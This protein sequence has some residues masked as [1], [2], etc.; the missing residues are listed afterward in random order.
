MPKIKLTKTNVE[1]IPFTEK[2]QKIYF[3][4][5]LKG[6]GLLV[7][8]TVKSY[9]A[10]KDVRRRTCR[11]N[12]GRHPAWSVEEARKKARYYTNLMDNGQDPRELEAQE[13]AKNITFKQAWD[14]HRELLVRKEGS[15]RT[16]EIY[17]YNINKHL[18]DW[19]KRP[20]NSIKRSEVRE[21]HTILGSDHGIYEANRT[22]RNFRAVYNTALKEYEHLPPNPVIA[23]QWFKERRRQEPIADNKLAAWYKKVMAMRSPVRKDLQLFLIFT[24]LRRTDACTIR[25]EDINLEKA[26][27]H[28]PNPK[29]GKD[30]AFTVP[31]P[32]IC[33]EILE[34]RK[35][36]NKILY[37]NKCEWVFPTYNAHNELIGVREPKERRRDLPSPHRLRDTYTTAANSAGLSPYDIDVL[38][39]HRPPNGSV[40]AGYIR[41][42][43]EYLRA[44]QQKIAD[45]LKEKM[46][47]IENK[48]LQFK[49][50]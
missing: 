50:V 4:T 17:D 3:D 43:A 31:I 18:G 44:Q 8:P 15:P 1:N 5:E 2:G 19:L 29:G 16:L 30:F 6:F 37:G 28:R 25:W 21:R 39:N 32:D 48:I 35:A 27:L 11:I 49:R 12:I 20:L 38:T 45:Y 7:S 46:G 40:T 9:I 33:L 24:G 34:R 41:Q 22:M 26:T 23:V 36:Q 10:Q 42:D 47:I 13:K 14:I